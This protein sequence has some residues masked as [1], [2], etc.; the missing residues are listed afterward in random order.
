[1]TVVSEKAVY[2]FDLLTTNLMNSVSLL[3]E[4]LFFPN[5]IN[6]DQ[7][8]VS[9]SRYGILQA[10]KSINPSLPYI[11]EVVYSFILDAQVAVC[12]YDITNKHSFQVLKT[13][14]E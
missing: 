2:Y 14:V 13:W 10:R 4:L 8:K 1:M 12:V 5:C 7:E 6:T 9:H 3:S 11:T